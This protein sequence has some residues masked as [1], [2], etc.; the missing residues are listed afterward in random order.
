M[1]TLILGICELRMS[2]S[3]PTRTPVPPVVLTDW[4]EENKS[5]MAPPVGAVNMFPE[6]DSY[7]IICVSGPNVRADYHINE[8]EEYF[9]QLEGDMVLKI[10]DNGVF[11]DVPIKA[12]EVFL[13]PPL[14]P[15]SPQRPANTIGLVV[16][17][18]RDAEHVDKLAFYCDDCH[19]L[20]YMDQ[21]H[22]TNLPKQIEVVDT[23]YAN[24]DLRTCANCGT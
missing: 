20:L 9:M 21:F 5:R 19:I 3:E 15:H 24:E 4:V 23:F 16:E 18:K 10:I 22:C 17:R 8:T 13:L 1:G 6:S 7:V 2:S 11:R 12:G 14:V